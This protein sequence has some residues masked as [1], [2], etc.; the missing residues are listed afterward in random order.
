MHQLLQIRETIDSSDMG[1]LMGGVRVCVCANVSPVMCKEKN[2]EY[3]P[4]VLVYRGIY[5]VPNCFSTLRLPIY[6]EI[7]NSLK[8]IKRESTIYT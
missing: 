4:E 1:S 7:S 8:N 2:L 5:L 3:F 6:T